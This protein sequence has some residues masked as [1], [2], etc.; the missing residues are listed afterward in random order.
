MRRARVA[1]ERPLKRADDMIDLIT[2]LVPIGAASSGGEERGQGDDGSD[3]GTQRRL[4][5]CARAMRAC[6]GILAS[7]CRGVKSARCARS[8]YAS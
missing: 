8:R 6:E 4:E 2:W 5:E 3:G 1:L 7:Q